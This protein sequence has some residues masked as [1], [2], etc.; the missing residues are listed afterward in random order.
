M[1]VKGVMLLTSRIYIPN[2]KNTFRTDKRYTNK[3]KQSSHENRYKQSNTR[4]EG[5][6]TSTARRLKMS[7]TIK[8][9]MELGTQ[10]G[11]RP[12]H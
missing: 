1:C 10:R 12:F 9:F 8:Y 4:S 5:T 7:I 3:T 11:L 2:T 6:N